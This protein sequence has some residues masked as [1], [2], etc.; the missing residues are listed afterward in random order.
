[1][2]FNLCV[3][4]LYD[5]FDVEIWSIYIGVLVLASWNSFAFASENVLWAACYLRD[6]FN[7][8]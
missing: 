1:M 5:A 3:R 6:A 2:L 8:S 4:V 7:T